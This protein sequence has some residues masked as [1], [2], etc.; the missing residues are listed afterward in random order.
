V[1]PKAKRRGVAARG[2]ARRSCVGGTGLRSR[3]CRGAKLPNRATTGAAE[4]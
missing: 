3:R 2:R 4:D 1:P